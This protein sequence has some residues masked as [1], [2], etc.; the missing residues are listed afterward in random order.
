AGAPRLLPAPGGRKPYSPRASRSSRMR[1]RRAL[2]FSVWNV[3]ESL[4]RLSAALVTSPV[5]ARNSRRSSFTSMRSSWY[6]AAETP[7]GVRTTNSSGTRTR[8]F[9]ALFWMTPF[10]WPLAM[11]A[12]AT[13][14]SEPPVFQPTVSVPT[15]VSLPATMAY[16]PTSAGAATSESAVLATAV[17]TRDGAEGAAALSLA[18][19]GAAGAAGRLVFAAEIIAWITFSGT[20]ACFNSTSAAADTS[21]LLGAPSI[22]LRMV[23]SDNPAFTSWTTS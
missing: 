11:P 3:I 1:N 10:T 20:F 17:V 12:V 23:L 18:G 16:T 7:S 6:S 5:S 22:A 8:R 15:G 9:D 13:F 4:S 21:K 2:T 19:E 14:F